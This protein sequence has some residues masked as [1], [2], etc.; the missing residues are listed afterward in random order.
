VPFSDSGFF[1]SVL[2]SLVSF[3][4]VMGCR[5]FQKL[6]ARWADDS[7]ILNLVIGQSEK[8]RAVADF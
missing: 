1:S 7:Q 3:G 8:G 5:Q 4:G 2:L 6:K